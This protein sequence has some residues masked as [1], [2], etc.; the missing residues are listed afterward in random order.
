MNAAKYD[1]EIFIF[2]LV[3]PTFPSRA[4]FPKSTKGFHKSLVKTRVILAEMLTEMVRTHFCDV[5]CRLLKPRAET[6]VLKDKSF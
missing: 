2:V 1:I 6:A 3:F 5:Q 4:P